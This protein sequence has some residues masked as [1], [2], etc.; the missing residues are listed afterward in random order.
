MSPSAALSSD[1]FLIYA[2]VVLGLLIAGGLL[3]A[4]LRWGLHRNVSHAW[5]SYTSWLVMIPL[6]LAG[7]FA[8]RVPFI[9]L[10]SLLAVFAFKE[11]AR[12][13][14]LYRD[15]LMT[16]VV[17]VGILATGLVSMILDPVLNVP[18]WYGLFA[19][20][21]AYVIAAIM[22]IPILRNRCEGQL[23][24]IALAILGFLYIGWMFGHLAFLANAKEAY[25][26]LLYLIFA[27]EINDVAA[28]TFG[29]L[30]GR[31]PLRS[32][33][34][35]KKTWEGALGALAVSMVLPWLLRF[36][37]PHF[38]I[39]E[40]ILTGVIVGIAGQ[41][42]DLSMSVIKRDLG[43]KDMGVLIRGHGGILDRIDSLIYV[44]PLFFHMV[45]WFHGIY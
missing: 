16:G 45:R 5:Q 29:K 26:Y 27:V 18:G 37:F 28:Y 9:V 7:I 15:W 32:N 22:L 40:L 41:L 23:Q 33:I 30:F 34:S 21:P 44:T 36:S 6:V 42:G 12:A 24:A 39:L 3:I 19:I 1:V 11:Y 43:I 17:Y 20:L 13:T 2:C 14:G 10:V 31:H 8:G 25:G 4:T 35:R 38:T